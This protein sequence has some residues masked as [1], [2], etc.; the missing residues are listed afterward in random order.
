MIANR[1]IIDTQ[2]VASL[3]LGQVATAVAGAV[4]CS[5]LALA[6]QLVTLQLLALALKHRTEGRFLPGGIPTGSTVFQTYR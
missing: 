2:K 5:S 3:N 1:H 6:K 4:L